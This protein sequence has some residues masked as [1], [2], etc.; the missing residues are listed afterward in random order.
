MKPRRR[1]QYVVLIYHVTRQ[2]IHYMR[3]IIYDVVMNATVRPQDARP[4][5]HIIRHG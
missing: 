2:L 5:G 1:H 3:I 4:S